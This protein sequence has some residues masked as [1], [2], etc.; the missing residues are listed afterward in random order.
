M[1]RKWDCA[2]RREEEGDMTTVERQELF[3]ATFLSAVTG[4]KSIP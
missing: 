3:M 1:K 4:Y 2:L